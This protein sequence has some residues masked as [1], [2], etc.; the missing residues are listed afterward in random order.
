MSYKVCP[1]CGSEVPE[2]ATRCK[3]CFHDFSEVP[4]RRAR[5]T[6]PLAVLASVAAMAIVGS[7]VLFFVVNRPIEERVL[8]DEDTR[9][10]VW[11][12][13]FRNTIETDRLM[14]DEITKLE[15]VRTSDGGFEVAAIDTEGTRHVIQES[16]EQD[17]RSEAT[18]Y[19]RLMDKPLDEIDNTTRFGR[20][21]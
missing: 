19:A 14:F 9:S 7:L 6:G 1:S 16:P 17:L 8:V 20:E 11:T 15:Y 12:R 4:A 10:V 3:Q 21:G 13:K 18:A 2:A 5:K